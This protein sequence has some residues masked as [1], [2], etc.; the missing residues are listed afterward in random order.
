MQIPVRKVFERTNFI[1]TKLEQLLRK[2]GKN[3]IQF[4]NRKLFAKFFDAENWKKIENSNFFSK[5]I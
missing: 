4:F 2:L 3:S 1:K 5:K